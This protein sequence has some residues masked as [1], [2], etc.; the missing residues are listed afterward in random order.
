[1]KTI[2]LVGGFTWLATLDYYRIINETVA[3]RLGGRHSAKMIIS[4]IDFEEHLQLHDLEGWEGV[5][6]EIVE[7]GNRLRTA[8]ADFLVLTANTLHRVADDVE[9]GVGLPVLH[10]ADA[11]AAAIKARGMRTVGILGTRHTVTGDFWIKR[12]ADRHGLTV[13][14]SDADDIRLVDDIIYNELTAGRFEDRAR[15]VC[16]GVIDRLVQ[17]GAEGI[18][19][20]CTEL[21]LLIRAGDTSATLFDTLTLHAQAAAE[22]A[23]EK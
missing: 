6:R 8:G 17:T 11:T 19:L 7:I 22:R 2:G 18:V 20:G 14:A 16:L 21:P 4:S 3:A 13:L 5:R 1:M 9:A 23:L 15:M 12:A 10:I